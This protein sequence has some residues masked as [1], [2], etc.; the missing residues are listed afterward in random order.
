MAAWIR[1]MV[2]SR[3]RMS[4]KCASARAQ[5]CL[6][7]V[8]LK[9]FRQIAVTV[10]LL[11]LVQSLSSGVTIR[12]DQDSKA[13]LW[14]V[15]GEHNTV[16][17]LGS[18]HVLSKQSYPLKAVLDRAFDES[19]Q[20]AFE[21]DLTRFTEQSFREEFSRTAFYPPG[22]SLSKNLSPGTIELLNGLLPLY[23]LTLRQVEGQKPWF[24]AETLSSRA[25]ERAG[26]SEEL[27]V[28]LY[29][30]HKAKA[31]G[32]PVLGLE[33]LRD[34]AE[35][36][37]QFNDQQNEQYLLNTISGLRAY[38]EMIRK[39]VEAWREGDI[40]TLDRLLNQDKRADPV[41]HDVLFS[42]RNLKWVPEI[43]HFAHGNGN[44]LVIVGAGHLVGD[45]GVVAQ[46]RR[47]GYSVDQL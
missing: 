18:I 42:K 47:A 5:I 40:Q 34:Q 45:D 28:D 6:P 30:F 44:Y 14:R 11:F 41:T 43:E 2:R 7:T 22:Q 16:Y 37:G 32:K 3:C 13:T 35:I 26:F 12:G 36:F 25:L 17:L 46:L 15:R 31:L 1:P 39:L 19:N 27:G 24:L 9:D 38:S 8:E 21:I 10:G 23:G 4:T 20:V 29:F 33:T